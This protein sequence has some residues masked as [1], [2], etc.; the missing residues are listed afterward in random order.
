[1]M[2]DSAAVCERAAAHPAVVAA[3][4]R[5]TALVPNVRG[6]E[7]AMGAGLTE[8][9]VFAS[10]SETFSRRNINQSIEASLAGYGEVC[11]T[12]LES[13]M[14]V[15]GYV[16]ATFGCPYEGAVSLAAV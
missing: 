7:R 5:L 4:T 13:G 14:R 12:A 8:I 1:Q 10:A 15:R 3:G 2:A 16:S 6:L 11:A 9:A